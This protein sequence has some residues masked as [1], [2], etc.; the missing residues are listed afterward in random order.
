M[1]MILMMLSA[2]LVFSAS[3]VAQTPAPTPAKTITISERSAPAPKKAM[4]ADAAKKAPFRPTKDQIKEA[5]GKLKAKGTYSGEENGTYNDPFREAIKGFQK[6]NGLE[7]NGKL[8]RATLEKMGIALTDKQMGTEPAVKSDAAAKPDSGEKPKR[9]PVF[10]ATKDQINEAQR[11]LKAGNMYSGEE[12]GKLD[13]AT[14][15]GLKKY[16]EANGLKV[17]GT[18][19]Q[20]TLEKMGIA[21]TDKQKANAAAAEANK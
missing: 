3:I 6:E 10:R 14:R 20:I 17:T 9:G 16:Q 12:I 13:D 11:K 19:N 1:K 2:S 21:L 18:L 7:V 8:D 4:P 5:Q 15:E